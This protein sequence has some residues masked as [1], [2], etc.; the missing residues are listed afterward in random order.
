MISKYKNFGLIIC[1]CGLLVSRLVVIWLSPITLLDK[2]IPDDSWM[3]LSL[4]ESVSSGIGT[5]Y[6]GVLTNGFQP[7]FLFFLSLIFSFLPYDYFSG[8]QLSLTL[9]AIFELIS[10]VAF[11]YLLDISRFKISNKVKL[12]IILSWTLNPYAFLCAV[13]GLETSLACATA[14]L[15]LYYFIKSDMLSD[16]CKVLTCFFSGTFFGLSCLARID[17]LLLI[18]IVSIY[19]LF[20]QIYNRTRFKEIFFKM[21][22]FGF[23]V[24]IF[25]L[26]WLI[27]SRVIFGNW[28]PSSGTAT[29]FQ[30]LFLVAHDPT[31]TNWYIPMIGTTCAILVLSN[32]NLMIAGYVGYRNNNRQLCLGVDLE[33]SSYRQILIILSLWCLSLYFAYTFYIFG[34]WYFERYYFSTLPLLLLI[35]IPTLNKLSLKMSSFRWYIFSTISYAIIIVVGVVQ[36]QLP[37]LLGNELP[38]VRKY[39]SAA[40]WIDSTIPQGAV[41]GAVQSGAIG[42]FVQDRKVINLDGKLDPK[43]LD[44]LIQNRAMEYIYSA[45]V[46]HIVG[47]PSNIEY[48]LYHS[49]PYEM[50]PLKLLAQKNIDNRPWQIWQ[51]AGN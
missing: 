15:A 46:T 31:M 20:I 50:F 43:V 22:S 34:P 3:Y 9:G 12:W 35:V 5:Q 33:G 51:V 2:L 49:Q 32:L 37:A 39:V 36:F 48:I 47:W 21:L 26:P 45:G 1:L 41:I 29:R 25:F 23:G 42:Y 6:Q 24:S 30:S 8:I 18:A 38:S 28:L 27:W 13:N 44:A 10:V 40:K 4:A 14:L 19:F 16:H 17:A 7:L 11:L